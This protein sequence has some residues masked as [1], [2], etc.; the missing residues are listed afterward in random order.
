LIF[1]PAIFTLMDDVGRFF[2]WLFSRF[3]GPT[4]EAVATGTAAPMPDLSPALPSV[5][6]TSTPDAHN[7]PASGPMAAAAE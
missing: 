4:D 5:V 3:I 2:W 6:S 1:V 7:A